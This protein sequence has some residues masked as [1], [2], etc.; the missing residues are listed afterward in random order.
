[1]ESPGHGRGTTV[2]VS[3]PL[4]QE[5]PPPAPERRPAAIE[6]GKKLRVL[7]LED[8]VD[9]NEALT[10]LLELRGYTVT[11]AL[12]V[13]SALEIA[14]RQDFDLLLSDLG[15][16]DGSPGEVMKLVAARNGTIGI[17]LSGLGMEK[18]FERSRSLG[19]RHHLVKPVDVGRLEEVLQEFG[20]P[21]GQ[22]EEATV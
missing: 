16:P 17:A 12:D 20:K 13:S 1:M 4:A 15:L 11:P 21:A 6:Q 2:K 8:H 19:F 7:L 9:T 14:S 18:D 10:M 22:P 3:L 5:V